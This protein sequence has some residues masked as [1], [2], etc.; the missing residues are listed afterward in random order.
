VEPT[1]LPKIAVDCEVFSVFLGLLPPQPSPDE[2]Q[3]GK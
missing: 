3:A 1:E 2:N